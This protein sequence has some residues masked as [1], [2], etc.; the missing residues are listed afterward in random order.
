M[1]AAI[2][3]LEP[4]VVVN[5]A[6]WTAVD[7]AED[8]PERAFAVNAEAAGE[9]ARGAALAGAPVIQ[10]STDYVFDGAKTAPYVETDP[11]APLGVYGRS[12]LAGELAVAGANER[13]VI[14]RLQWLYAAQGQNF[15]RTMLRL[16]GTRPEI[17]VV[18]D[19]FGCPTHAPTPRGSSSGSRGRCTPPRP[20]RPCAACS[21]SARRATRRAGRT[22]PKPSSQAR[23]SAGCPTPG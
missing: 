20:T 6:A 17:G 2:A 18:A 19:Q 3:A 7:K 9:V 14:L 23:R 4:D 15:V 22:S 10:I 5:A 12:K 21:I 13:H 16:A 1:A 8:E 11:V